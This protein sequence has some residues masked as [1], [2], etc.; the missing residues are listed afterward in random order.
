M[1]YT[2]MTTHACLLP[3]YLRPGKY[4]QC[5]FLYVF[6]CVSCSVLLSGYCCR[7]ISWTLFAIIYTH[8]ELYPAALQAPLLLLFFLIII[9]ASFNAL[10]N[11]FYFVWCENCDF[12]FLFHFAWYCFAFLFI[13]KSLV[14]DMPLLY[15]MQVDFTLRINLKIFLL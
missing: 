12:I 1:K 7:I 8:C 11:K 10:W 4:C 13:V 3:A 9:V 6:P 14:Y 2:L 15:C 5:V